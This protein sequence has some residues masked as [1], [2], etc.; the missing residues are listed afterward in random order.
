MFA[1]VKD[2]SNHR[3]PPQSPAFPRL[4]TGSPPFCTSN[5]QARAQ[6]GG[7]AGF[8]GRGSRGR[9]A[10]V[11]TVGSAALAGRASRGRRATVSPVGSAALAG[12]ASGRRATVS[13]VARLLPSRGNSSMVGAPTAPLGLCFPPSTTAVSRRCAWF[14]DRHR[15]LGSQPARSLASGQPR[16]RGAEPYRQACC[17]ASGPRCQT[18]GGTL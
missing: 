1:H 9:R 3:A 13:P 10:T 18:Q 14:R 2:L 4:R 7:S 5:P 15:G 11:S 6:H 16:N 17:D 8:A 12:R